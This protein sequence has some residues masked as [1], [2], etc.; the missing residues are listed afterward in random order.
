MM[1][2]DI[3]IEVLTMDWNLLKEETMIFNKDYLDKDLNDANCLLNLLPQ[4]KFPRFVRQWN[5]LLE[6][7]CKGGA[8]F[9]N[10]DDFA[11]LS[12]AVF[13]KLQENFLLMQGKE[14]RKHPCFKVFLGSEEQ[15]KEAKKSLTKRRHFDAFSFDEIVYSVKEERK[16]E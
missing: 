2:N 8:V 12:T 16:D 4:R 9:V 5:G 15:I 7:Y 1:E 10:N 3:K 14:Y 13:Q 6:A 11:I